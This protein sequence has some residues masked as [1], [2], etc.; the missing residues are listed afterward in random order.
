[1]TNSPSI[2]RRIFIVGAPRSGTTLLQSLLAAHSRMTSFTESHLFRKHFSHLPLF[3][4]PVLTANPYPHLLAFLAENG[5]EPTPSVRWFES[6]QRWYAASRLMLPLQTRTVSRRLLAVLDEITLRRGVSSWIEKTPWHLRH[7]SL[8]EKTSPQDRTHF[9]HVI[10]RGP[11]VVAS[12]HRASRSWERAYDL[13]SCA[14]RWNEDMARSLTRVGRPNHHFVVYEKLTAAPEITTRE[15]VEGLGLVWEPEILDRYSA[16][17][18]EIVGNDETWKHGV[19]RSISPSA[20]SQVELDEAQRRHV[21][22]MLDSGLY[23][24]LVEHS[25][26]SDGR[27]R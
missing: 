27:R 24:R 9:I 17:A 1:M 4:D 18:D 20:T 2:E 6:R 25:V 23:D 11:E 16:A 5:E 22:T 7:I 15:L 12:L 14:R 13:D 3:P 21:N 10:R 19:G 8:L 26:E